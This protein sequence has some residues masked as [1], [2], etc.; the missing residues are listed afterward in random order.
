V[1]L[2]FLKFTGIFTKKLPLESSESENQYSLSEAKTKGNYSNER[3]LIIL[4]LLNAFRIDES[5]I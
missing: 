2:L 1:L 5:L 4:R 3:L